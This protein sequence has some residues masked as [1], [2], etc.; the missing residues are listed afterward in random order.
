MREPFYQQ[1]SE[2]CVLSLRKL[3][4]H[5]STLPELSCAARSPVLLISLQLA[6]QMLEPTWISATVLCCIDTHMGFPILAITVH[7]CPMSREH[8]LSITFFFFFLSSN[9]L[10]PFCDLNILVVLLQSRYLDPGDYLQHRSCQPKQ[11]HLINKHCIYT[12]SP[13]S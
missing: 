2:H 4:R 13:P 9:A 10:G 7:N 11:F 5:P 8:P 6:Q 12:S 1:H 3:Q